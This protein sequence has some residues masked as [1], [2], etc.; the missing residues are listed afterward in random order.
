M[1]SK[2]NP[3]L[4]FD[5][6]AREAME[7]YRDTFGGEL[8]V[9]TFGEYGTDDPSVKDNTMHAQLETE[10]GFT[11]MASDTAPGMP[12]PPQDTKITV[13]L[14]GD[15]GD[16]LRGYWEKL[17]AGGNVM[18]PLEKQMWGDEF[19]MLVDRFGVPWMVNIAGQH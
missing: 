10:N 14:S 7:F 19:G 1:A 18:M 9:S 4:Q 6:N 11:L 13:S 5:G 2:L 12:S 16:A 3:Y 17:S 15:D 8:T